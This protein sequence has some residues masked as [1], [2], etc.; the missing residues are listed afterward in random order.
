MPNRDQTPGLT[1]FTPSRRGVLRGLLTAYTASLI[2]WALA[3]TVDSPQQGAFQALSAIIAGRQ[4]LDNQLAHNLYR[5]LL[6]DDP[7]FD[8]A[9]SN[10]LKLIN[11]RGIDPMQ[12]QRV[13][14]AEYPALAP[15]PRKIASAWLMG[16]VGSGE[17]ARCLAYEQALN[18]LMVADVLKPPTYAYGVYGSW[19]SNPTAEVANV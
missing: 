8:S 4:S 15:L 12:L 14:D 9:T 13:L 6:A 3:E 1:A 2:P 17:Q 16:V 18:A 11:E 19:A 5:A 10:L 7:D